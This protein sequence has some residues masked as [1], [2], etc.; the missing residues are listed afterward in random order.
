MPSDS[1]SS[2]PGAFAD[3]ASMRHRAGQ[4]SKTGGQLISVGTQRIFCTVFFQAPRIIVGGH[5]AIYGFFIFIV[6]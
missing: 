1:V 6:V 3:L 5:D 4:Q 2:K